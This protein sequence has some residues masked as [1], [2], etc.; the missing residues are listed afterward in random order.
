MRRK[1]SWP[2]IAVSV[3]AAAAVS[4]F[5]FQLLDRRPVLRIEATSVSPN[6]ATAGQPITITWTAREFR[7]CEGEVIR[8]IT[9]SR[10]RV[11]EYA[12]IASVVKDPA[13]PQP[14]TFFR[15]LQL[16][17]DISPGRAVYTSRVIRWCNI[18]QRVLWPMTEENPAIPFIVKG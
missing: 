18:V 3:F 12:R 16:A 13:A 11:Y 10:G 14:R 1:R 8:W 7:M 17:K 15:E 4:W 2:T 9:D 5:A 6:P